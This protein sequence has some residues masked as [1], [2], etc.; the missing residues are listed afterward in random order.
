MQSIDKSLV[1]RYLLLLQDSI[2]AALQAEDGASWKEDNWVR[3]EGG[4]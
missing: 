3:D 4:G 1:K 2:C